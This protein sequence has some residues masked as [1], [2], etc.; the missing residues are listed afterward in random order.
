MFDEITLNERHGDTDPL[1]PMIAECKRLYELADEIRGRAQKIEDGLPE[2]IE[3]TQ[4]FDTLVAELDAKHRETK[5][6][7]KIRD[8]IDVQK[9]R[10]DA[11][12]EASGSAAVDREADATWNQARE[13]EKTILTTPAVTLAGVLAQLQM[14]YDDDSFEGG[15]EL[16]A[17]V[18]GLEKIV[19]GGS[20]AP[21][22]PAPDDNKILTLFRE[23]VAATRASISLWKDGNSEEYDAA[24]ATIDDTI[25]RPI[26]ETPSSGAAGLAIK[27][28]LAI[29]ASGGGAR[30]DE[31][32]LNPKFGLN[33]LIE[34]SLLRDAARFVPEL[35]PLVAGAVESQPDERP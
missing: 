33:W 14:L 12:R 11:A 27:A 13:L 22:V 35:A 7:S 20:P 25:E 3:R 17:I 8:K 31:A 21:I 32:A 16:E 28:Y 29:R 24:A 18:A 1:L 2:G 9:P 23:W 10:Y 34:A 19:V 15:H 30:E 4:L 5:R 6:A 26:I